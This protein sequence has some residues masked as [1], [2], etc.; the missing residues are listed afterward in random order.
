[1]RRQY[2]LFKERALPD[3]GANIKCGNSLI[4]PDF[5]KNVQLDLLT[6]EQLID[7]NVFDWNRS[8]S[9]VFADGGF[10]AVIGN[11]PYVN[12]W[13]LFET[14]PYI[15]DYINNSG[16]F[17][18]ADRHWDLYV[19][20]MEK[21]LEVCR[22]NGLIGMIIP[23]SYA[24]Q[25]Y[26]EISRKQIL[27]G[28]EIHRVADL[29]TVKVFGKVPVITIIPILR[30][31]KP[32]ANNIIE[33][34]GPSPKATTYHPGTIQP[35]HRVAQARLKKLPEHML[36]IDFTEDVAALVAKIENDSIKL[37]DIT[38]VNY[39]AQMSSKKKGV[40]GKEYVLRDSKVT[41]TCRKTISGRD[42]Y[43]YRAN[44]HGRYVEWALAPEMYGSR[45]PWFF[46]NPK[47]MIRDITGN[48]RIEAARDQ[49]GLYCD[50]T[51]LCAQRLADLP[52]TQL[53][54]AGT[55]RVRLSELYSLDFLQAIVASRLISAY[56]YW[57]LT[58]EGVRT[59]GGF[60]TYPTTVRA[61]PIPK[62]TT[63]KDNANSKLIT[64]ISS[65]GARISENNAKLQDEKSPSRREQL[66]ERIQ[67]DDERIDGLVY[68]LY[69]LDKKQIALVEAAT[70]Q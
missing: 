8:F 55:A 52:A 67:A 32:R 1:M 28:T 49:T 11:P 7:V 54:K 34:D 2:E 16:I 4:G 53:A 27:A 17:L 21:A 41:A 58:G 64:E 56:Y 35:A 70:T 44:W 31:K 33:I 26:A 43:R 3:L 45:T 60:H 24:L 42:L 13:T 62:G 50:H 14:A 69:G 6:D 46:E 29:R 30:K 9:K 36:R 66:A 19:L 10:S 57:V 23:Y 65:L 25:K 61:L 39:G 63:M 59:G 15:R 18:S 47:L 22:P 37:G 40:F 48:H 38:H 51:I 5:R 20:F 68:R 12:A